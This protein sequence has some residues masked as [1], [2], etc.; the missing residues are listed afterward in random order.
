MPPIFSGAVPW[1][2]FS[3]VIA[4]DITPIILRGARRVD[5][6]GLARKTDIYAKANTGAI[7]FLAVVVFELFYE[8]I[9]S[10]CDFQKRFFVNA[11]H[12]QVE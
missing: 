3:R 11:W 2:R 4:P 8:R 5:V 10:A 6:R 1:K 12:P 9:G 7:L